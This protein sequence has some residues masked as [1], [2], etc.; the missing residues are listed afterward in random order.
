MKLFG[1]GDNDTLDGHM[2]RDVIFGGAGDDAENGGLGNDVLFG[3]LGNDTLNGDAGNDLLAGQD[4]NDT[5]N[6]GAGNDLLRGGDGDDTLTGGTG[7]DRLNGGA[8]ND[9]FIFAAHSG[10]DAIVDFKAHGDT[11]KIDL[12]QTAFDFK[13]LDDVLAHAHHAGPHATLIY[14]GGHDTVLLH[15]TEIASLKAEDFI[16]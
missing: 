15:H 10:H 12:S 13:T 3:G 7:H 8:G 4:G 2:L 14:L 5:L 9:T 1:T 16:L 6:G 11:D